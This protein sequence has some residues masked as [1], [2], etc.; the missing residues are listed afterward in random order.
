[1]KLIGPLSRDKD[2]LLQE[3]LFLL[4]EL[5][6]VRVE[7][8]DV[9]T[10]YHHIETNCGISSKLPSGRGHATKAKLEQAC[11]VCDFEFVIIIKFQWQQ[12]KLMQFISEY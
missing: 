6:K 5:N 9:K 4:E 10:R 11:L 2:K 1:M 7:L 8:D 12:T 3:N